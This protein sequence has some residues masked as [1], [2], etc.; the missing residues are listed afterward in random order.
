MAIYYKLYQNKQEGSAFNGRWYGRAV[1][2][3]KP[4][5]TK[6]LAKA[7]V[8]KCTVTYPDILAV[9]SALQTEIIAQLQA[10][11]RV[12]LEDFGSFKI[13]MATRPAESAEKFSVTSN[14]KGLHVLFQPIVT[15][16]AATRKHSN[17]WVAGCRVQSLADYD[18]PAA[19]AKEAAKAAKP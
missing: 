7:I 16:D 5:T 8:D 11:H 15:V 17:D 1:Q 4:A 19:A 18:D 9:I 3:G 13:G 6:V 2:I 12:V 10:G 14:V